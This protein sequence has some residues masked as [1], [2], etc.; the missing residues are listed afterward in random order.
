MAPNKFDKHI[1]KQFDN[2]EIQASGDAWEKL[3]EKLD[4]IV[5]PKKKRYL[6]Y[7]VAASVIG[8]LFLSILYFDSSTSVD[9]VQDT[10]VNTGEDVIEPVI[11]DKTFKEVDVTIVEIEL[12]KNAEEEEKLGEEIQNSKFKEQIT[13][14]AEL[15]IKDEKIFESEYSNEKLISAKLLEIV[16]VVDSLEQDN[17]ALSDVEVV[18]LLRNAQQEILRDRL[19]QKS[20]AV[21]AAALLTQVETELDASFRDKVFENLKDGFQKVRTAVANRNN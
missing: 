8:L 13:I 18:V 15:D 14:N 5:Y 6:W 10:I 11:N 7:A 17:I 20:G 9:P 4:V 2:R 16:A 12:K 21:D 1:K 3:N 19:L